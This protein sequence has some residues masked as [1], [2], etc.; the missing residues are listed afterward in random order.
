MM[1]IDE[2]IIE[3]A[4]NAG[5]KLEIT[6]LINED[7]TNVLWYGGVIATAQKDG[8]SIE[9][10]AWGSVKATLIRKNIVAAE[11]HD[12][13][14]EGEFYDTMSKLIRNDK[15]LCMIKTEHRNPNRRKE[16]IITYENYFSWEVINTENGELPFVACGICHENDILSVLSTSSLNSMF[17]SAKR[18]IAKGA[19]CI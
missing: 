4:E 18:Q 5:I 15:E 10:S 2:K 12:R 16:L 9:I 13:Y 11:V 17:D 1:E 7:H 8:I 3:K 19:F 14:N 6:Q